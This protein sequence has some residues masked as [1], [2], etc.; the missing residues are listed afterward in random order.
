M[1][2][3]HTF[4][5]AG[6]VEEGT[7]LRVA[8]VDADAEAR[9]RLRAWLSGRHGIDIVGEAAT[10]GDAAGLIR[11]T[12]ADLV[13]A[14]TDIRGTDMLQLIDLLEEVGASLLVL[15]GGARA[16]SPAFEAGG[17]D[18][19]IGP[20]AEN[21]LDRVFRV[22]HHSKSAS[23]PGG[24]AESSPRVDG[25]RSGEW[26]HWLSVPVGDRYI[27][28]HTRDIRFI[29]GAGNY[30]RIHTESRAVLFRSTLTRLEQ[31][32]NPSMFARIHRSTIVNVESVREIFAE[33]GGDFIVAL[34][35]GERLR[36]SRN[37]RSS[38]LR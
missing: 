20:P 12:G 36:M 34:N 24:V 13:L 33:G 23:G 5:V 38:L 17:S 8:I 30:V 29:E 1:A 32:L 28:I 16:V 37:Y 18:G 10:L 27:L 25:L 2:H 6:E 11:E 35:S 3:G 22:A 4:R 9:G 19:V 26:I 15:S 31:R 21:R 14:E 7:T